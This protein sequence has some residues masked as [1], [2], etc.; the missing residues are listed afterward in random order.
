VR[1]LS[2]TTLTVPKDKPAVFYFFTASCSSC[3]AGAKSVGAGVAKAGSAVQA[4]AVDLDPAEP[5]KVIDG[6][7]Q[8]VGSPPFAVVRDNGSLQQRFNVDALGLTVVLDKSGRVVY[9]GVDPSTAQ[10][11]AAIAAA[12]R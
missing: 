2:G 1:T 4:V 11:V 10:T 12:G 5:V 6:F 9:R 8:Y 7:M 3:V